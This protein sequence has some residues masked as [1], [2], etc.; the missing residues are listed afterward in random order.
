MAVACLLRRRSPDSI[1]GRTGAS[2]GRGEPS[3]FAALTAREDEVAPRAG[4]LRAIAIWPQV[5][6][7]ARRA[8]LTSASPTGTHLPTVTR[9][10]AM[11]A[12]TRPAGRPMPAL[13]RR[14]PRPGSGLAPLWLAVTWG[15]AEVNS[16][17][18]PRVRPARWQKA[19]RYG[20]HDGPVA[21]MH[22]STETCPDDRRRP[23]Q[24]L[25]HSHL[26]ISPWQVC[27]SLANVAQ[28][29]RPYVVTERKV[30]PGWILRSAR[31]GPVR[32]EAFGCGVLA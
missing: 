5:A 31:A 9:H 2:V 11:P 19:K 30:C 15:V 13:D 27:T 10:P 21:V 7:P 6:L 14:R 22:V 28:M 23:I 3:Q 20:G 29:S 18:A 17:V 1:S 24:A 25:S 32:A 16:S 8:R 26:L 4:P 12:V